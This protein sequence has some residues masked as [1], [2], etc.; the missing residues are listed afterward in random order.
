V[1]RNRIDPRRIKI[2]RSYTIEELASQL[3][4]HKNT[5]RGWTKQGLMPLADG[6][7]PFLFQGTD[8]R[9]FLES[10]RAK[11]KHRCQPQE[12]FCFTCRAPRRAAGGMVDYWRDAF[13]RR[14]SGHCSECST[15]MFKRASAA[16][17]ERLKNSPDVKII[18]SIRT[19]KWVA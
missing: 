2:H 3:G 15:L 7:R 6:Q 10:R 9:A 18:E 8:V 16:L 1:A 12:L 19:P 17:V 14:I 11:A 13:G 5:A 4:C